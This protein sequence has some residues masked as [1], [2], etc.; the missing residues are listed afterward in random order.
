MVA[1]IKCVLS[2]SHGN[3]TPER[4]FSINKLILEVHGYSTYEDTLTALRLVKDELLRVGGKTKLITKELLADVKTSYTRY[5]ADRIAKKAGQEAE[6]RSKKDSEAADGA[7]RESIHKEVKKVENDISE[8]KYGISVAND[9]ILQA[10]SDLV[11]G[12]GQ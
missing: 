4:G 10:Q 8:A 1:F 12:S 6:L 2:L 9:L 11:K 7:A 5:E 3:I